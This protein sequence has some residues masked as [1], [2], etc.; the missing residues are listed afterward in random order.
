MVEMV[1]NLSLNPKN[2]CG[3]SFKPQSLS[4]YGHEYRNHFMDLQSD[5]KSNA[6][7]ANSCGFNFVTMRNKRRNLYSD[8]FKPH[9][10]SSFGH[11]YRS[12]Y[13]CMPNLLYLGSDIRSHTWC[14][15]RYGLN[16]ES[17]CE[18]RH[19]LSGLSLLEFTE[20]KLF[21]S[22][23]DEEDILIGKSKDDKG[24]K[25]T[26]PEEMNEEK[27]SWRI[28]K[29]SQSNKTRSA[30]ELYK[31]MKHS[32]LRP[33][34]HASNSFIACLLRCGM[35]DDALRIFESLKMSE[36]VSG[37]TYS[38]VL[39][40]IASGR[41]YDEATEL[42]E[43]LERVGKVKKDFDVVAY[44]TIISVCGKVNDWV[45]TM[46]IWR[47]MKDNGI[48]GTIVTYRLLVCIFVRCGQNE[49]AIDAYLEL[50]QN[51]FDPGKD[52][53]Q[54]VI[55]ACSKEGN[56][57]LALEVF[58][59]MLEK[60]LRPNL[61]TCNALIN[62]LGKEGKAKLAFN[63]FGVMKSLGH[64]PDEYTWKALLNALYRAKRH[65][66]VLQFFESIRKEQ[67]SELN[68][69]L[70]NNCLMSCRRLGFWDK[71]LKIL[72]DMEVSGLPLSATSYNLVIGACEY[73]RK[74]EIA[75][76]VYEHMIDQKCDPDSFTLLSLIRCC[77]WGSLW[78]KVEE[79][80]KVM[81]DASL[82]NAA[83]QGMCLSGKINLATKLYGEMRSNN[84][85]PDGK[86]RALMLQNLQKDSMILHNR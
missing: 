66:D 41:S 17:V 37:H 73:A 71:S 51:D 10:L 26:F 11:D 61:I 77:A 21:E 30:M 84:L 34:L 43:E 86:T 8:S 57:E 53:M 7:C 23:S 52:E 3:H 44:N 69:H 75:L 6:W 29:L 28:V 50:I 49:S 38:L 27:L 60:E 12:S 83:I 72:R 45:Q 62:T 33:D 1:S 18:K 36:T 54:A 15:K 85:K 65:G 56:W 67:N 24:I 31:S 79:L 68:L 35:L 16:A 76:Q 78:Y 63:V 9:S 2:L 46:R 80:L 14:A 64:L 4:S 74:P 40:A 42:F 22:A 81:P 5:I 48:M 25:L 19:D 58:E 70:Y 82:Y 59:S 32:G 13:M 39:K 47:C 20:N 55:G